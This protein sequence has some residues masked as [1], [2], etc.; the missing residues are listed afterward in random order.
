[1]N[2]INE[3]LIEVHSSLCSKEEIIK[4]VAGLLFAENR[5]TDRDGFIADLYAREEELST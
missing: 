2:L 4:Q 5:I 3:R 1:M